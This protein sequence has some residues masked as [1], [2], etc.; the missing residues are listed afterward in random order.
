MRQGLLAPH[1]RRVR[2]E[3]ARRRAAL[4]DALDRHVSL[5]HAMPA[6]G[7]LHMVARLEPGVDEARATAAC[8]ARG[9]PVAPL[10]AYYA[11]RPLVSGLVIGFACTPEALAGDT[12]RRFE[13]ALRAARA[14]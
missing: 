4:L 12:A 7:G 3:Y 14:E 5:A 13:A 2:T 8:R 6:P 10:A 9:L 1:I 11:D